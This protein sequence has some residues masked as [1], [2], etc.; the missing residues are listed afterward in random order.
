MACRCSKPTTAGKAAVKK[1]AKGAARSKAKGVAKKPAAKAK[2]PGIRRVNLSAV[3]TPK[4][5]V[6]RVTQTSTTR[7]FFGSCGATYTL[8]QLNGQAA[9]FNLIQNV[10]SC[11]FVVFCVTRSG[12]VISGTEHTFLPNTLNAKYGAPAGTQFVLF[13]CLTGG[14]SCVLRTTI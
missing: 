14:S 4:M 6:V 10:G 9:I 2:S 11:S 5:R 7:D 12:T 3:K 8:A 1:A 13:R